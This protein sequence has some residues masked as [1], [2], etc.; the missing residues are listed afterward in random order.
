MY[1]FLVAG[2]DQVS[3]S[4]DTMLLVT[5]DTRNKTVDAISLLRD[6]MIN[7]SATRGAQ[8]RLNV[9]YTRNRGSSDLPEKERVEKGMTALK[10]EVSHLTGIYPDF[11]VLVEW[12]AVG[13]LVDAIGGVYFEVPFD[14]NYDD[15]TP[16][17]D[18]HIHQEAGYRLLDGRDAME[19]IRF[20]KNNDGTH[21]L[22]GS[23]RTAIQ[24]DFLTAVIKEC[25]Q[26]DILLK[27]PALAQIFTENVSTDLSVGNILAFAQLAI[28]MDAEEDVKFVSLPWTGVSYDGASLVL[29]NEKELLLLLNDG[30]NPYVGEI[31]SSDLQLMYKKSG[32]GYGVTNGTLLDTRMAQPA[33]AQKPQEEEPTEEE[34]TDTPPAEEPV[35]GGENSGGETGTGQ[36]GG[37]SQ[38]EG[39]NGG[40]GQPP[41]GEGETGTEPPPIV[42]IDPDDV[43]PDPGSGSA[44]GQGAEEEPP[45]SQDIRP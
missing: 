27:L 30:L 1:T 45:P 8:K 13:E 38:G 3:N 23:G 2:L 19:V 32:G 21:A 7:T 24:R 28:G 20:R 4:T 10:Q 44:A 36:E 16:G 11:Y 33:V 6:T 39:E 9:V 37:S 26:P 42:T 31:Q 40:A 5:Y 12:E 41:E 14:M 22:G 25:L 35:G 17:Q 18:L 43:L 34:P 29:A 15:P